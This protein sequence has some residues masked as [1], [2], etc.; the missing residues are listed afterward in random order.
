MFVSGRCSRRRFLAGGLR[1]LTAMCL[2]AG[3]VLRRS[4]AATDPRPE[5]SA[6]GLGDVLEFCFGIRDAADDASIEIS[7]P[8]EVPRGELVPFR[9]SVPGAE[10]IAL[11][12]DANEK[13]LVMTM[14]QVQGNHAVL[15]GRARMGGSGHLACFAL[16]NGRLGRAVRRVELAGE[17][18]EVAQ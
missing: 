9:I 16:R 17:W 13:P 12:C 18:R 7:V 5:F 6:E 2:G 14:D 8:L 4:I 10:K 3:P 11:L 1:V 15:I